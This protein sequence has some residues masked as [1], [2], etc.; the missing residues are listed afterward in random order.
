MTETGEH[1][2]SILVSREEI[3][4]RV[5]E[6]GR[7]ISRDYAGSSLVLVGVLKGAVVF[8]ADLMRQIKVPVQVDFMAV[9]SYGDA[10]S[11]SGIVMINKDMD[12]DITARNVLLVEDIV[13]TGLT[14][15][16]IKSILSGRNPLDLKV[17]TMFDKPSRRRTDIN[18]DYC[19]VVIP[20][21]YVVGYGLDY[22]GLYREL[23][24]L[25]ILSAG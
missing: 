4:K 16:Y 13:D 3:A 14:L 17:C 5:M 15:R 23:P 19:G 20:D 22:K 11:S 6:L 21:K 8:M 12:M 24:D 2:D 10:T 25:C 18:P 1:I 7:E 9:S